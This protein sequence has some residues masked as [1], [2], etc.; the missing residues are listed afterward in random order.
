M[1]H[2]LDGKDHVKIAGVNDRNTSSCASKAGCRVSYT[3]ISANSPVL[4]T[5][6]SMLWVLSK[7]IR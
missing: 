4:S 1:P 6:C 5:V 3:E 7:G 2:R